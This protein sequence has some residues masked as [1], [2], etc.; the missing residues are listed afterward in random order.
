MNV[1]GVGYRSATVPSAA[2]ALG[3]SLS[4]APGPTDGLILK[5]EAHGHFT[6]LPRQRCQDA[7]ERIRAHVGNVLA[8]QSSEI[9]PAQ[10]VEH[11]SDQFDPRAPPRGDRLADAEVELT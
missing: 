8:A 7:A 10:H 9:V 5:D 1:A 4:P 6:L 2:T 3:F 11:L